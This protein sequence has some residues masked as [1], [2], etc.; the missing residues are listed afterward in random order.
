MVRTS[1]VSACIATI[2]PTTRTTLPLIQVRRW[3]SKIRA[4][5][6]TNSTDINSKLRTWKNANNNNNN[7]HMLVIKQIK[8]PHPQQAILRGI[9][10][11]KAARTTVVVCLAWFSQQCSMILSKPL[12]VMSWSSVFSSSSRLP[13]KAVSSRDRVFFFFL[14][15]GSFVI[16]TDKALNTPAMAW[17]FAQC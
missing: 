7:E 10:K 15:V 17:P 3:L 2:S 14:G 16:Y 12:D 6:Q 11:T 13:T 9:Q 5:Q 1:L 8:R 4:L